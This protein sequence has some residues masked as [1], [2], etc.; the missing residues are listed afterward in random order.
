M[1]GL[2]RPLRR[3]LPL[4]G[5]SAVLALLSL[6]LTACAGGSSTPA[7]ASTACAGG[8]S[9]PGPSGSSGGTAVIAIDSDPDTLNLAMTTAYSAGDVGSKIFEGLIWLDRNFSP[10]PALSTSWTT[11]SDGKTYTF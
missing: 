8:S 1:P 2:V 7:P 3:R 6:A 11:S 4:H 10:H 9:V 5:V